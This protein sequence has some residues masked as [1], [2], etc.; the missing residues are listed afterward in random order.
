[1]DSLGTALNIDAIASTGLTVY[2]VLA[3]TWACSMGID[4]LRTPSPDVTVEHPLLVA[5]YQFSDDALFRPTL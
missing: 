4:L 5:G 1:M 2:L 3:P